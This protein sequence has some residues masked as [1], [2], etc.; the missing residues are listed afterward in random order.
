M[1]AKKMPIGRDAGVPGKHTGGAG[2]QTL[3]LQGFSDLPSRGHA[4]HDKIHGH[5]LPGRMRKLPKLPKNFGEI[6]E[7]YKSGSP[8]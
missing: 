8:R 4:G 3:D 6:G 1:R 7:P 2:H 5:R